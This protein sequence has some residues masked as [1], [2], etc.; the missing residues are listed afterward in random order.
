MKIFGCLLLAM[1]LPL[2][3]S[4]CVAQTAGTSMGAA[5]TDAP[6][7]AIRYPETNGGLEHL[8]KDMLSALQHGDE[9]RAAELA[10]SMVLPDPAAWFHGTFGL[11]SSGREIIDYENETGDFPKSILGFF[12]NALKAGATSVYVMRYDATQCDDSVGEGVYGLLEAR[13]NATPMYELRLMKGNEFF[14]MW[15]VVYF[16]GTFRFT[17]KPRPWGYFAPRPEPKS[18]PP[19]K[20]DTPVERPYGV[21]PAQLVKQVKPSYP[22]KARQERLSGI[23]RLH[24]LIGRDG[25]VQQLRV[26]KGYCSLAP[27]ALEAVRKW[28][29]TPTM[30]NGEPVEVDTTL[31]VVFMLNHQ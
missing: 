16:A 13:V 24:A 6:R 18:A 14:R 9:G 4:V 23:V 1:M 3:G 29:Y 19:G 22:E 17:G 27:A 12:R 28:R 15:P 25:T 30:L 10:R 8:G 26:E 21:T 2:L 20:A 11:F 5:Q 7:P 31:D